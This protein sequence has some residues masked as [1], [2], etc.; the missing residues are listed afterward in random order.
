MKQDKLLKILEDKKLKLSLKA[1]YKLLMAK[2]L[3]IKLVNC[4]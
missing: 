3:K 1:R 4:F 2:M